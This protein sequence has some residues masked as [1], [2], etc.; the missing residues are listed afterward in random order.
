MGE[1]I[2]DQE[3][4]R[5]LLAF[6]TVVPPVTSTTRNLLLKKLASLESKQSSNTAASN[7]MPPP[8]LR[9]LANGTNESIIISSSMD[10][11]NSQHKTFDNMN[12]PRKSVR[13]QRKY[14]APDLFDTSD[15]EVDTGTLGHSILSANPYI[16]SSSPKSNETSLMNVSN[17]K[18]S[19]DQQNLYVSPETKNS[20]VKK[21]EIQSD[22]ITSKPFDSKAIKRSTVVIEPI[23][24]SSVSKTPS[25]ADQAIQRWK[26]KMKNQS[27]DENNLPKTTSLFNSPSPISKMPSKSL[28]KNFVQSTRQK[29]LINYTKNT[30]IIMLLFV[31][32]FAVCFG[33]YFVAVQPSKTVLPTSILSSL[34]AKKGF[35]GL[36]CD[37]EQEKVQRL[38]N[39]LVMQVQDKYIKNQCDKSDIEPIINPQTVFEYISTHENL[40]SREIEELV[41]LFK[42]IAKTYSD[43][44]I[45]FDTSFKI[46]VQPNLPILCA[47]KHIF[48]NMF[49]LITWIGIVALSIVGLYFVICYIS[50]K[51][52]NY[53]QE[54]NQ[55]VENT[56][57]LLKEQARNKPNESYL[58]IIHIRDHL[59]PFNERQAKSKI[60]AEV[61]QYFTESESSVR[62]EVQEIDGE[63]FQVWR[64]VQP[65]SPGVSMS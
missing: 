36:D 31:G 65:M 56:I 26:E 15:S 12:S 19:H 55:L 30:Q 28:R 17:W 64:W 41:E 23:R 27:Q 3:L 33:L 7:I 20:P 16:A 6:N 18:N 9:G 61:V 63:D 43:S 32:F 45:G 13:Q 50:T 14:Q 34:C 37:T 39:L 51:S 40:P 60:W 57:D 52:E 25:H 5:R 47:T 35:Q 1:I 58:P 38:Y 54:V 49:Y 59:I 21:Y 62:S 46:N 44:P 24:L 29:N 22:K 4:R 2:S 53:K 8:K 10:G 42:S 48:S 11:K